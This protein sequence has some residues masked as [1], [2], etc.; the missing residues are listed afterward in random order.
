MAAPTGTAGTIKLYQT[1]GSTVIATLNDDA[2]AGDVGNVSV[3][4][5]YNPQPI[6]WP[7][8][9]GDAGSIQ[10][11][12]ST[13]DVI[14]VSG[15]LN[16]EYDTNKGFEAGGTVDS[17]FS[18]FKTNSDAQ[19]GAYL[20]IGTKVFG[21]TPNRL[22]AKSSAGKKHLMEFVFAFNIVSITV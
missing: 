7:N 12:I 17:I 3:E 10:I 9:G 2:T 15:Y 4:R 11:Q 18:H 22:T 19:Q 1:N 6:L 20:T 8:P 16:T 14:T 5:T 21:V 13:E